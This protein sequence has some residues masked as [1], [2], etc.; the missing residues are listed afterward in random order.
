MI[1]VLIKCSAGKIVQVYRRAWL[2]VL[3]RPED[4]GA[5]AQ[6]QECWTAASNQPPINSPREFNFITAVKELIL[7]F[8]LTQLNHFIIILTNESPINY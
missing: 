4:I 1:P 6:D 7:N 8:Y 3:C 2:L 5:L